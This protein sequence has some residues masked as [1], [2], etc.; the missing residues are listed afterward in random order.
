M[1]LGWVKTAVRLDAAPDGILFQL[2]AFA[3]A[4]TAPLASR[5]LL[6][7]LFGL[8]VGLAIIYVVRRIRPKFPGMAVL[9]GPAALVAWAGA[10]ASWS[11]TPSATLRAVLGLS[12]LLYA[13]ALLIG[14]ARETDTR[15]AVANGLVA[16]LCVA[17]VVYAFEWISWGWLTRLVHGFAWRDII[18]DV[19]GGTNVQSYLINGSSILSLLFWPALV[20]LRQ[21]GRMPLGLALGAGVAIIAA[22][23]GSD[24]AAIAFTVGALCWLAAGWLGPRA[25]YI[26]AVIFVIV[27]MT[28]PY[29]VHRTMATVDLDQVAAESSGKIPSSALIRFYI[30]R[31]A[32]ERIGERP[33]AGWGF[34]TA[35]SIPGGGDKF[36]AKD[37]KGAIL[38]EEFNLPLHPHNQILQIWL[39]LGAVGALIVALGGGWLIGRLGRWPVPARQGGLALAG[40]ALVYD[41]L[42]FGAWQGWWI[43]AVLFGVALLMPYVSESR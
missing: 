25:A 26:F 32:S 18:D 21:A 4:A 12:I 2:A 39:E 41:C 33:I 19:A 42:S 35:R 38:F 5:A 6:P 1:R 22:I 8:L 31:F 23:F 7:V 17:L 3:V 24:T 11:G 29:A 30:W 28:F 15:R 34:D 37:G 36:T 13:G 9:A 40:C 10:S 20:G 27:V 16:G 43:A 14:W